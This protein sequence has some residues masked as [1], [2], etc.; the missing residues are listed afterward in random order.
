MSPPESLLPTLI[1]A[2][3]MLEGFQ[4]LGWGEDSSALAFLLQSSCPPLPPVPL[5]ASSFTRIPD[6]DC[7][8][9]L[10]TFLPSWK[11]PP[12]IQ[13]TLEDGNC[14]DHA[15]L[16]ALYGKTDPETAFLLRV[17]KGLHFIRN[18]EIY[19]HHMYGMGDITGDLDFFCPIFFIDKKYQTP[20]HDLPAAFVMQRPISCFY[21]E[22]P[23]QEQLQF[24]FT[25]LFA[26][27]LPQTPG[28]FKLFGKAGSS[29]GDRSTFQAN[30][31]FNL[32]F[33]DGD[34]Q[35][36]NIVKP[37]QYLNLSSLRETQPS[38]GALERASDFLR[39]KLSAFFQP[40]IPPPIGRENTQN[41]TSSPPEAEAKQEK[42][43]PKTPS[44]I[45]LRKPEKVDFFDLKQRQQRQQQQQRQQRQQQQQK[46]QKQQKQQ[47]Q[48]Q[49]Q[50]ATVLQTRDD[51]LFHTIA[52]LDTAVETKIRL[53]V[54]LFL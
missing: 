53:P 10:S 19:K 18:L 54:I 17:L 20:F 7:H 5:S 40:P 42:D 31:F 38:Q 51:S 47:Q 41:V 48:Q 32:S 36:H 43:A 1:I 29:W 12:L 52:L 22:I 27:T 4:V 33:R 49:Q 8:A 2:S 25:N 3:I 6:Q 14:L 34:P 35:K 28:V 13:I 44:I 23:L 24:T 46:Q 15:T 9:Q 45:R 21:P 37:P 39:K 50:Q 30:H 16:L 11:D 26:E